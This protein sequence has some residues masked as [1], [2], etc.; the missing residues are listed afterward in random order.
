MFERRS[1]HF[2]D[3]KDKT[4]LALYQS[5]NQPQISPEPGVVPEM[6]QAF[7]VAIEMEDHA[8]RLFV[9]LHFLESNNLIVYQ[10]E[11]FKKEKLSEVLSQAEA[12]AGEMGF[13]M[14]DLHYLDATEDSR[15]EMIRV[16][17]CFYRE[18]Q[19]YQQALRD[20]DLDFKKTQTESLVTKE[21]QAERSLNFLDQYIRILSSI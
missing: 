21:T 11:A 12:F 3:I 18:L 10:T 8:T 6:A 19:T 15:R 4:L 13:M 16:I 1:D 14:D 2:I 20:S 9:V 7:F 17:P 5:L